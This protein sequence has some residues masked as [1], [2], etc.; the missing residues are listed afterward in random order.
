LESGDRK[1]PRASVQVK[2]AAA[3]KETPQAWQVLQPRRKV[4]F[5]AKAK[6]TKT[7]SA[8]SKHRVALGSDAVRKRE[9]KK[10]MQTEQDSFQMRQRFRER[11]YL[12]EVYEVWWSWPASERMSFARQAARLSKKAARPS[13]HPIRVLID[14]TSSATNEK[15][16]SRWAL[17]LRLAD[18]LSAPPSKLEKLGKKHG[19]VAGCA[20]AYAAHLKK[21]G[22][23][24]QNNSLELRQK[25]RA[26]V[27]ER[28]ESRCSG[29]RHPHPPPWPVPPAG[30]LSRSVD[31]GELRR[32]AQ[33]G[34][35]D[36][37]MNSP[38]ANRVNEIH[39]K[40]FE[41]RIYGGR[42]ARAGAAWA[43]CPVCMV[44]I[45]ACPSG[46]PHTAHTVSAWQTSSMTFAISARRSLEAKA[47]PIRLS[48]KKKCEI[49]RS[50][51][52]GAVTG[53]V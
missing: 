51:D 22:A 7:A 15:M 5:M 35:R 19:G 21:L 26:K 48:A 31:R 42:P 44:C 23:K 28:E 24:K 8:V 16:R 47:P 12:Q 52:R 36:P 3:T 45:S 38:Q 9:L 1:C 4:K 39:E 46:R 11:F 32:P 18:V 41:S 50:Q 20:R 14:C 53:G 25:N 29:T 37:G 17:A 27:K 10:L 13:S 40:N 6:K 30:G 34:S 49:A 2:A 33:S 43:N